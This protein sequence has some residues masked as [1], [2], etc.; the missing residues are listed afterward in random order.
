MEHV[1]DIKT[2]VME[3]ETEMENEVFVSNEIEAEEEKK[4]P[5]GAF[6]SLKLNKFIIYGLSFLLPFVAMVII[7][8]TFGVYP[9]GEKTVL[10]FDLSAQFSIFLDYFRRVLL[11]EESL[12]Y[13]FSKGMGGNMY[14]LFTYYLSSPFSLL[15][16][17]FSQETLPEAIAF[18]ITIKIACAGLT[19][20][21]FLKNIFKR[22]DLAVVAFSCIYALSGYMMQYSM[23]IMW[24]DGVIWLPIIL[25]GVERILKGKSG[26]LFVFS[27]AVSMISSYYTG[28]IN[29]VFV[30]LWFFSRYFT[31]NEKIDI[32]DLL[33]KVLTIALWGLVGLLI[34][35]VILIPGFMDILNGK[36]SWDK[37]TSNVPKQ[38]LSHNITKLPAQLFTAQFTEFMNKAY[39]PVFCSMLSGV[40]TSFY[41]LNKSIKKRDKIVTVCMFFIFLLSFFIIRIDMIWH[42]FQYPNGFPYRYAYCF[43]LF[44]IYTAFKG[45]DA[46]EKAD[47]KT[48]IVAFL[49][50]IIIIADKFIFENAS[51]AN[52]TNALIS[53]GFIL[54][55]GII[56]FFMYF[57][58]KKFSSLLSVILL[59]VLFAELTLG[60][61]LTL[62]ALSGKVTYKPKGEFVKFNKDMHEVDDFIAGRTREKFIRWD[63]TFGPTRND[64]L[65]T[66]N[67][68]TT[69][70]VSNFNGNLMWIYDKI[71]L[72]YSS[73]VTRYDG[74]TIITDSILGMN[75]IVS[76]KPVNDEYSEIKTL[77][78]RNIYRN[79]YALPLGF[80]VDDDILT[81]LEYTENYLENQDILARALLD[82]DEPYGMNIGEIEKKGTK[83]S[84]T[85]TEDGL[86]YVSLIS[87]YTGTKFEMT[88][89]GEKI[90]DLYNNGSAKTHCLGYFKGG[91]EITL[92]LSK[93][94]FIKEAKIYGF[95]PEKIKEDLLRK[96]EDARFLV[97]EKRKTGLS[98]EA[99]L[100]DGEVLFTTIPYEKGWE[101]TANGEKVEVKS[102]QH[103]FLA[104]ELPAG[105]YDIEFSYHVPGLKISFV[106]SIV[107]LL[108]VIIYAFMKK[109]NSKK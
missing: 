6:S 95:K 11:G 104:L 81:D 98:A 5:R 89:N 23:C 32:K 65:M 102:A 3:S 64:S 68:S 63:K 105:K 55:Y 45:F 77:E 37:A 20:S 41:F 72:L 4:V 76:E 86:Y 61:S 8:A 100:K 108:G 88:K 80:A 52:K 47:A 91:D 18:I 84:F 51:L 66:G 34:S 58:K 57:S 15:M 87:R 101:A 43:C 79:N 54:V 90:D 69:S 70:F 96:K 35:A 39:P 31:Q 92:T 62:T 25:L 22:S 1:E 9:F 83:L 7:Y 106:I 44:C 29:T 42:I 67:S 99:E 14:G 53:I 16:I 30:V 75:F 78:G 17:F 27:Y 24:L 10:A 33:K 28:Y 46:K 60:G 21:I 103:G 12:F 107:S 74:S 59:A 73:I 94:S 38:I 48:A 36:L 93:E 2:G 56:V 97:T 40:F 71:G 109:A 49:A 85:V 26:I 19:F 13:A 50:Y 82:S